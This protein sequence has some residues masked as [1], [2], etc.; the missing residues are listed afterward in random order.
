MLYGIGKEI[1]PDTL[2]EYEGKGYIAEPKY[3]G[4]FLTVE[5]DENGKVTGTTRNGF[6]KK[7]Y[8]KGLPKESAFVGEYVKGKFKVYSSGKIILLRKK[9]INF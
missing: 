7:L 9:L 5:T 6:N 1:N 8:Y 2:N 3:D 4:I